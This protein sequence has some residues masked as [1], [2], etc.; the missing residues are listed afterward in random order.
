[1]HHLRCEVVR[2][3][4]AFSVLT[5]TWDAL[6]G[7]TPR[8]TAFQGRS[9]CHLAWLMSEQPVEPIVLVAYRGATVIGLLP[10]GLRVSTRGPFLW[11][12]L[13][14]MAPGRLDSLDLLAAPGDS[15]DAVEVMGRALADHLVEWDDLGL[16]PVRGDAALL[17]LHGA[18]TSPARLPISSPVRSEALGL[19]F[20]L[21][22]SSWEDLVSGETRR[23]LRRH[24]RE[25]E[26]QALTV[27]RAS[28][29]LNIFA[30]AEA[31]VDLHTRRRRELGGD[32]SLA[33]RLAREHLPALVENAV[34]HGGDLW[35]LTA[36]RKAIAAMLTLR[37]G[38]VMHH[39]RLAF[40]SAHRQLA[41]GV[42]LLTHV[43]DAAVRDGVRHYDFGVGV[44]VYKQ[45]W[46]NTSTPLH[47]LEARTRQLARLPARAWVA[48]SGVSWAA[49]AY[50]WLR[51]KLPRH[52][53][54]PAGLP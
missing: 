34:L 30:V 5:E 25:A 52:N 45:R 2:G 29:G 31:L 38:A 42:V 1:M 43:L 12:T 21:G 18:S 6:C 54:Q 41:P 44:E 10:L 7:V 53:V 37:H 22:A 11:R 23:S 32:S 16:W 19:D 36:G 48:V 50:S 27:F 4:V 40:D 28:T 47:G 39:Y 24:F 15:G 8:A 13:G 46:A 35:V 51:R 20:P 3:E 26:R 9:V 49:K 17:R 33:G 14:S